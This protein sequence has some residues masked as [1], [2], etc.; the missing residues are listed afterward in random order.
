MCQ[1]SRGRWERKG[2]VSKVQN[3]TRGMGCS[4]NSTDMQKLRQNLV[5]VMSSWLTSRILL[6]F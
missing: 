5:T 2:G 1:A 4:E 3:G 6:G